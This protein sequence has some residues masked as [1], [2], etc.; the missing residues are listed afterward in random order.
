M[1][2]DNAS[3]FSNL[4]QNGLVR[5]TFP[6]PPNIRLI[7]PATNQPSSE[8]EVDVWRA[9]PTVNDV[10]LTGPD[11]GILWPRGPNERGGY[12]LD[13]RFGTLQ[14]QALAAL[15][16]HA[17]IQSAP[18]QQLLDDLSSFQRVLF[19]NER[20]RALSN[21]VREGDATL[22][23]PDRR[24]TPLEQQGKAVFERACG[25]CHGGPGQST[26]QATPNNPPAPVIRFHTILSQCPRPVDPGGRFVFAQCSPQLARNART[27]AIALSID[28][29]TPTGVLPA[30]TIVRRTSSDPG[31]A[32][33]TGFVGGPVRAVLRRG[34][35]GKS[36]MCPDFEASAGRRRTSINN[37]AATLEEMLDHYDV[38]VQA[39][40]GELRPGTHGCRAPDRDDRRRELRSTAGARRARRAA[41]LPEE[42]VDRRRY[43]GG[44]V[45]QEDVGVLA[46]SVEHEEFPVGGDVEGVQ[47]AAIAEVRELAGCARDEVEEPEVFG[48]N[49]AAGRPAPTRSAGNDGLRRFGPPLPAVA[50]RC[51]P[52]SRHGAGYAS[53]AAEA[54]G[55]D[56]QVTFRRPDG[57]ERIRRDEPF[58]RAAVNRDHE[59]ARTL[60]VSATCDDPGAVGRP[61]RRAL[62][63]NALDLDGRSQGSRVGAISRHDGEA[64]LPL[65]SDDNRHPAAIRRHRGG[66]GQDTVGALPHFER[67]PVLDPPEPVAGP[68]GRKREIEQGRPIEAWCQGPLRRRRIGFRIAILDPRHRAVARATGWPWGWRRSRPR[69]GR[70]GWPTPTCTARVRRSRDAWPCSRCRGPTATGLTSRRHAPR[71]AACARSSGARKFTS[72]CWCV[73]CSGCSPDGFIRHTSIRAGRSGSVHEVDPLAVWRP[74][75]IVCV[76]ALPEKRPGRGPGPGRWDGGP[77]RSGLRAR[78]DRRARWCQ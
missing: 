73:S 39:R 46:R 24:L 42:A 25:Q 35:T 74:H 19:T 45:D 70:S 59:Q 23:D 4:R 54:A 51:R 75:G 29:P 49:R 5:I 32:L 72:A 77:R 78:T 9:V 57:I 66:L 68:A 71:R 37:S 31:R 53:S 8:T 16:N 14:E 61:V 15:T 13:G 21:A 1:N 34:T 43:F 67:L 26:P 18:P 50:R 69:G 63:H 17:Q 56:N 3:D 40:G 65:L 10:A 27:Y 76:H 12:Q 64:P 62:P 36:S 60:R 7:D 11:D 22:P 28:T 41:C 58:R 44:Q 30:G 20:V 52:A 55:I 2:G 38:L 47:V 48:F 6:L 33:L